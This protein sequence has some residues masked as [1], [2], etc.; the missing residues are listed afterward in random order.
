MSS[1]LLVVEEDTQMR[2]RLVRVLREAGWSVETAAN[3]QSALALVASRSYDAVVSNVAMTGMDGLEALSRIKWRYPWLGSVIISPSR[4]EDLLLRSLRAGAGD[5]LQRPFTPEELV[6]AVER[7][8][9]MKSQSQRGNSHSHL[10]RKTLLQ[11]IQAITISLDLAGAPG[12]P[13]QGLH[14]LGILAR[15]LAQAHDLAPG[16]CEEVQ[17]ATWIQA[18]CDLP[19]ESPLVIDREELPT[20]TQKILQ[21]L[22]TPEAPVESRLVDLVLALGRGDDITEQGRFDPELVEVVLTRN[23]S[24]QAQTQEAS[25]KRAMLSRARALDNSQQSVEAIRL[26][27]QVLKADPGSPDR[28]ESALSLARLRKRADVANQ[29]I[30]AAQKIGPWLNAETCFEAGIVLA[31][32]KASSAETSLQRSNR[33]YR[34][35]DSRHRQAL[36]TLA[37]EYFSATPLSPELVK[38]AVEALG[39][40]PEKELLSRHLDWLAPWLL[41]YPAFDEVPEALRLVQNWLEEDSEKIASLLRQGAWSEAARLG[42]AKA[43]TKLPWVPGEQVLRLLRADPNSELRALLQSDKITVGPALP[44][45]LRVYSL[46]PL[47]VYQ[48]Q[49]RLPSNAWRTQRAKHL[50]AFLAAHSDQAHSEESL[51]EQF[52][53]DESTPERLA[54]VLEA[55]R[56]SLRPQG[57][58]DVDYIQASQGKIR[59]NL[60]LP[61]W[62]DLEH[63]ERSYTLAQQSDGKEAAD[64]YRRIVTL[65]R[66]QFLEDC[67][68][69]WVPPIRERVHEK[70]CASLLWLAKWSQRAGRPAE[71]FEHATRL[72]ESDPQREE[73]GVLVMDA[74]IALNRIEE[75]LRFFERCKTQL[76]IGQA[77]QSAQKRAIAA[78][79]Y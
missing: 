24:N 74:L 8:L 61:R 12:R 70:V 28:I 66:G 34:D 50:F 54:Q 4:N 42:L 9:R 60:Q 6:Q 47:E 35:L 13:L 31:E 72:V 5:F 53:S 57:W 29:A 15:Q 39:S 69:D 2:A 1:R 52:V 58:P 65:A 11:A 7:Q 14:S 51:M 26:Y 63:L 67:T 62:H 38:T 78:L 49:R 20:S 75:A 16:L 55:A 44:P 22:L 68:L 73:A 37:Q 41:A 77:L 10:V 25:Q 36:A 3:G 23:K 21:E 30:Q 46:G 19:G 18:I 71:A 43:M 33:L 17:L 40:C 79:T 32:I 76:T 48:G 45:A 59:L 64:L 56:V 27:E